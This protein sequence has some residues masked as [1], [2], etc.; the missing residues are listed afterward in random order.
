MNEMKITFGENTEIL[1][2]EDKLNPSSI[3]DA[4]DTLPMFGGN[5]ILV[6]KIREFFSRKEYS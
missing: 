6:I 3:Q 2:F 1:K 4:F 5:K